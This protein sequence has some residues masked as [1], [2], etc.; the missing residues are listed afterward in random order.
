TYSTDVS[1]LLDNTEG[2]RIFIPHSVFLVTEINTIDNATIEVE[3]RALRGLGSKFT[4]P[5][6]QIN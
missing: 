3:M 2:T 6:I 1:S 5:P 4:P